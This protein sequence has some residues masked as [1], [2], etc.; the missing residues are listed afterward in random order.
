L[1]EYEKR[2]AEAVRV[3][4]EWAIPFIDT[5]HGSAAWETAVGG[6]GQDREGG[7]RSSACFRLRLAKTAACA[8][9]R[10]FDLF[11]TSLSSGRQK[12]SSVINAIGAVVGRQAGAAFLAEDWKKG[13]RQEKA[14]RLVAER[15]IYR[16]DYCGCRYSLASRDQAKR[17]PEK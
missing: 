16:Q 9:E 4:R 5:D 3:C 15:G 14:G 8:R 13:G 7:P 10:A 12:N 11:A 1:A 2:K 6:I 17:R